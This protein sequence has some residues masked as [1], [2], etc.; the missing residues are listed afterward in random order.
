MVRAE[1]SITNTFT[2]P[3]RPDL[4]GRAGARVCDSTSM[5]HLKPL[6]ERL[7][8]GGFVGLEFAGMFSQFGSQ[9]TVVDR[10][11]R[12]MRHQDADVAAAVQT[13]LEEQG[14]ETS[15]PATVIFVHG[16][17]TS[18]TLWRHQEEHLGRLGIP[19]AAI[20]LPG[21]GSR[22]GERFFVHSSLEGIG[23]AVAAAEAS[24]TKPYLVGFSL[25]G[26]LAIEWVARNPGRVAGLLAAACATVPHPVVMHGWRAIS[27]VIGTFP[28][29]GRALND[30]T[31]RLFVPEPGATDVIAGGVALDV[32]DDVLLSLLELRPLERLAEIDVPVLFVNGRFDHVRAHAGRY[33]AATRNGRLIT[34]PGA[35]HMVSVVRPHA[36][37]DALLEG[38]RDATSA[39]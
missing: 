11:D 23:D 39:G 18:A 20:D 12:L 31:V 17:R 19:T 34:V 14:V 15:M 16:L 5:Q 26:Y 1:T 29:R 32:M 2:V 27:K 37:T 28:D 8:I 33:L 9:V 24:H 21:H 10:S 4:P 6:P 13:L 38:Y 3:A 30:F 35:S 22:L 25:G 7:V 36:F